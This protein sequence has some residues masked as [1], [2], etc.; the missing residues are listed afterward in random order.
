MAD[1]LL[2]TRKERARL[3]WLKLAAGAGPALLVAVIVLA[4]GGGVAAW[5]IAIFGLCIGV[6]VATYARTIRG[7]VIGGVVLAA[8]LV[9]FQ[10]VVAWFVTH[11]IERGS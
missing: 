4:A 7:A 3:F 10:M 8:L 6:I 1:G 2:L 5:T 9:V 11:P